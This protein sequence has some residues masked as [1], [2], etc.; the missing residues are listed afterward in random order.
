MGSSGQRYIMR[1]SKPHCTDC[2]EEDY[3]VKCQS[4]H[5]TIGLHTEQVEYEG[6]VWHADRRCFQCE[7]CKKDLLGKSFLPKYDNT[8]VFCGYE[9]ADSFERHSLSEAFKYPAPPE[10]I[11]ESIQKPYS[12]YCS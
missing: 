12:P 6:K 5:G 4:C 3:A 2:F 8:I 9:C 10:P 7:A 1:D 11:Y